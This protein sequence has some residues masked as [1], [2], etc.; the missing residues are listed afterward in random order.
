VSEYPLQLSDVELGRYQ[1]MAEGA[2]V[3]EADLWTAA[4][5]VDGAAVADVGCGPGAVSAVLSR[6]VGPAGRVV[7]VDRD[8][9]AVATARTVAAA[10]NVTASVGEAHD[11]GVAPSSVDVVMIR[12]VLAHNG[13]REQAI[14]DHAATLVR[15][16]GAVYIADIDTTA[17][18]YRPSVPE[19]DELTT[20]YE[21]WHAR[22]GN[23]LSVGLRL[24]ELL[25]GAGLE[26]VAHHG[27]YQ[28]WPALAGFRPP[29]WAARDALVADGLASGEDVDRWGAMFERVDREEV[30]PT[31]FV[32]LFFAYGRR[33]VA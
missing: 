5:V 19:L 1:R 33:P 12:H 30:R 7:A 17:V 23:D 8:P 3:N 2:A 25:A 22:R 11:T 29:A 21:E 31:T 28:I 10:G 15:P 9:N 32:P 4:G 18:R 24:G 14:V 26:G 16:G 13:G 20:R 27:R 6:V